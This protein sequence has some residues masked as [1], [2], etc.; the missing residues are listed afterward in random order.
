MEEIINMSLNQTLSRTIITSLT[1]LIVVLILF[2]WGGEVI[3]YFAFAL[4]V[5]VVTGTYSSI[6]VASPFM[7]YLSLKYPMQEEGE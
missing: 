7:L 2:V 1:T 3:K 6:F 5:G 4:I